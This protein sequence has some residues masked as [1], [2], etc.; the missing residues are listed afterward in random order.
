MAKKFLNE[1]ERAYTRVLIFCSSQEEL[2]TLKS[3]LPII[4]GYWDAF[5]DIDEA[6]KALD[7]GM[8][9][10]VIADFT[11]LNP[12][13]RDL[14]LLANSWSTRIRSVC[15]SWRTRCD[16]TSQIWNL[17]DGYCFRYKG[18]ELDAMTVSLYSMF[19]ETSHLKWFS[20]MQGEFHAMRARVARDKSQT[21]L[22]VGAA[23]TG[24]FTLAQ[25]AHIRSQRR[26]S[27]FVFANCDSLV[28]QP[29]MKWGDKE[30]S[31]FAKILRRMIEDAQGGTLYFHEIDRLEIEA[32]EILVNILEKDLAVNTDKTK[33]NGIIICS[34]RRN[35]EECVPAHICSARLV[36][37]L[38]RNIIKVPSISD[39]QEDI[40]LLV[41]DMLKNY[42]ISQKIQPKV[43]TKEAMG[44]MTS[45]IW[46]R[47]LREMFDVIKHAVSITKTK[48]IPADSIIMQPVID[49]RDN[50]IDKERKVKQALRECKGKKRHAAKMLE[51]APK[52]LYE[53]MKKLGIPTDYK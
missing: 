9:G 43:F 13:G 47:N 37:F 48:R 20:H 40:D 11:S 7:S 30:K 31:H 51:I 53:W 39:Y 15:M 32:Q 25:I 8:Y 27:K 29:V 36:Q 10:V 42:C 44:L 41:N 2:D 33:F 4:E 12:E 34:S 24:K 50:S 35:M 22:L 5:T 3:T 38:R 28:R 21:V 19:T 16:V 52:T 46:S 17:G 18:E 14:F 23:G 49:E 6:R 26:N 1:P 45:H